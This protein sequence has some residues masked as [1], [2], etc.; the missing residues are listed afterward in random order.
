MYSVI[1]VMMTL[2]EGQV[3]DSP[4]APKYIIVKLSANK[5]A[6][7]ELSCLASNDEGSWPE[8]RVIEEAVGASNIMELKNKCAKLNRY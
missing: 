8:Y 6:L 7:A 4:N 5:S 1:N 3:M 2:I